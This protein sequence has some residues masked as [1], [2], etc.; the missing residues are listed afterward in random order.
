MNIFYLH[1][2]PTKC[3]RMHNDKHCVKM[4]LEY[5]QLLSTAHHMTDSPIAD[6]VYRPT[7]KNHPSAIWTRESADNYKWLYSLFIALCHEYTHRYNKI[8]KTHYNLGGLL[9]TIP[10]LPEIGL[11]DIP[12]CM[13]DECKRD[14]PIDGYR[15]Y[16]F[17]EKAHL[18]GWKNRKT[19]NWWIANK[20]ANLAA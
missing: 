16:Y 10:K 15:N 2:D 18:A 6:Q 7:H 20:F 13:P 1:H 17:T 19:P 12:Q 11:T 5:A 4:I 3:A 14:N 9:Q 8:H